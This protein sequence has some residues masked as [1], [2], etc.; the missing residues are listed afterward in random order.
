VFTKDGRFAFVSNR[1]SDTVS[2]IDV[3]RLAEVKQI[4]VGKYPQ[5]M[6]VVDVPVR[7]VPEKAKAEG[8]ARAKEGR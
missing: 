8:A 4:A 5:R 1:V 6:R 7:R 2:V 3:D